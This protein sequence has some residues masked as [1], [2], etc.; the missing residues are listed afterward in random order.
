MFCLAEHIV[1]LQKYV[2]AFKSAFLIAG[3]GPQSEMALSM[4]TSFMAEVDALWIL[5]ETPS[6]AAGK[7]TLVVNAELGVS[8]MQRVDALPDL[9]APAVQQ[10]TAAARALVMQAQKKRGLPQG[11]SNNTAMPEGQTALVAHT[12]E[13]TAEAIVLQALAFERMVEVLP[14]FFRAGR[15]CHVALQLR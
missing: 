4:L 7:S 5:M 6:A 1:G 10:V 2:A 3:G 12:A 9:A 14:V 15:V 11:E 13:L 8:F